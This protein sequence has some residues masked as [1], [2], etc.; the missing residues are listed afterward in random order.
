VYSKLGNAQ[1]YFYLGWLVLLS[2]LPFY[3]Y[4]TRV[5][6]PKFA[7]AVKSQPG[8]AAAPG[9]PAPGK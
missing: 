4:R 8:F 6:D 1:I 3:W 5:E 9:T 2:Y 7:G